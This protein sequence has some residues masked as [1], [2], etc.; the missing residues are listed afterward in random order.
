VTIIRTMSFV[1]CRTFIQTIRM[2][3]TTCRGGYA[4][5]DDYRELVCHNSS[6]AQDNLT[7]SVAQDA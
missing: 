4:N 1:E 5:T 6:V 2:T 3:V 7:S